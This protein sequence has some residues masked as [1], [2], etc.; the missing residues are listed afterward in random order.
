MFIYSFLP[1]L[2]S[3]LICVSQKPKQGEL[4]YSPISVT[5][6]TKVCVLL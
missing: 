3:L 6:N 2:A 5:Y 4:P 1:L